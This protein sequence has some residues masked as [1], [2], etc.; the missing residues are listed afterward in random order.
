MKIL[1]TNDDGVDS[2]GLDTLRRELSGSHTLRVVAPDRERSATSHAV[3]LHEEVVF[4]EL[5][6]D[7]YSCSGT[8]AD[9]VL[10]T[11]LGAIDF[12]PDI[13]VSGI[14]HGANLGT[15]IIYSGTVGAARQAALMNFPGIAVSL[16]S[17]EHDADFR[18]AAA[19]IRDNLFHLSSHWD[20]EHFIN[21]NV[22]VTFL[23]GGSFTV[24]RPAKRVYSDKL[25]E[26]KGAGDK[27]AFSIQGSNSTAT[28]D[29][30]TDWNVVENGGVSVSP[31]FLHPLNHSAKEAYY[32]RMVGRSV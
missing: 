20:N 32:N 14:N 27:R 10:Y 16:V 9:C 26:R 7:R 8:P 22:P 1:L 12:V 2:I 25:I 5:G 13:V 28:G 11:L 21:V 4:H 19:F 17:K 31:I 23:G 30:I 3:T 24:A 18:P 6:D 15:D 29:G